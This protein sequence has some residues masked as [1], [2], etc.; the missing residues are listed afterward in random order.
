MK[1]PMHQAS[2]VDVESNPTVHG[3]AWPI[4]VETDVGKAESEGP[5]SPM[6]SRFQKVRYCCQRV[7]SIPY[8]SRNAFRMIST[9]RGSDWP[10]WVTELIAC[11]TGSIGVA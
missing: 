3:S 9:A 8:S 10:N 5:K 6:A 7:P 1:L 11:S 4:R 2:N